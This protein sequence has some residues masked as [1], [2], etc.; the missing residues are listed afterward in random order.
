MALALHRC[1]VGRTRFK[2]FE[3]CFMRHPN[4]FVAS[5]EAQSLIGVCWGSL[6]GNEVILHGIAVREEQWRMGIG[7]QL[8]R[9]F[10]REARKAGARRISLGAPLG[11]VEAF[12]VKNGYKPCLLRVRVERERLPLDY[13]EKDHAIVDERSYQ[14]TKVLYV[15]TIDDHVQQAE[16]LTRT[17]GAGDVICIFEKYV[18]HAQGLL[19]LQPTEQPGSVLRYPSISL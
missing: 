10:E 7:S 4:L 17:F 9:R 14:N 19:Q 5:Y 13:R 2:F 1:F 12:Y 15:K 11:E 18:G 6:R 8:L 16:E 3:R